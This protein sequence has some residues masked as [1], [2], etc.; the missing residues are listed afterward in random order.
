MWGDGLSAVS[1]DAWLRPLILAAR[2]WSWAARCSLRIRLDLTFSFSRVSSLHSSITNTG[3]QTSS[4]DSRIEGPGSRIQARGLS[5]EGQAPE[6]RLLRDPRSRLRVMKDQLKTPIC[7]IQNW[8]S[9]TQDPEPRIKKSRLQEPNGEV[10]IQNPRPMT[11]LQTQRGTAPESSFY[12]ADPKFQARGSRTQALDLDFLPL[13][14][15]TL[16]LL[17]LECP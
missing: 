6:H 8:R 10:Q 12:T 4:L 7:V 5:L 1:T 14:T 11:L 13:R 15:P 3:H 17:P 9:R 16:C 2:L